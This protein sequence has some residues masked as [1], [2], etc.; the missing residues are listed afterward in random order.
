MRTRRSILLYPFSLVYGLITSARNFLYNTGI[1]KSC[2]FKLPVICIGNLT[3]GGTGKTPH[4]EYLAGLL[5]KNFRIAIL[6]RGYKRRSHG[7]KIAGLDS[8]LTDLGDEP[9]QICRKFPDI[10]VAVDRNRKHGIDQILKV[11]PETEVIILDD[12]FQH[13]RIMPGLSILLSDFERPMMKDY[14]LPFGNLRE[15]IKNIK[16]ADIILIT[17][18]PQNLSSVHQKKISEE[19]GKSPQQKLYFTSVAYKDPVAVF[20]DMH[21]EHEF[22]SLSQIEASGIVLVTG[23]ANPGPLIE[24][25][26]KS[27]RKIIHLS[28]GDHYRFTLK[29]IDK[30]RSAWASLKASRKY[31]FTTEKDAARLQEFT[32][33]AEPMRSAFYYIPVEIHFLNDTKDEFDNLIVEYAGKNK[34]NN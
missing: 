17:K 7:F 3:V 2:K 13:R 25:L 34:R 28:F 24:Y 30:I 15:S 19:I 6:S 23:I 18:S 4:T 9:L 26:Q 5:R 22:F 1:I 20:E 14:L 32:N 10:T 16:R 12:G 11:K 29:D 21:A 8:T 27:F 33:I 31:V